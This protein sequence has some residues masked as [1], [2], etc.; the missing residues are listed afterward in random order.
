MKKHILVLLALVI[1][2][3]VHAGLEFHQAKT[4][5]TEGWV[6][7][8]LDDKPIWINPNIEMDSSQVESASLE[9]TKFYEQRKK[10][11]DERIAEFEKDHPGSTIKSSLNEYYISI[12]LTTNG[13]AIFQEITTKLC[14]DRLAIIN[15]GELLYA[16]NVNEPITGGIVWIASNNKSKS[17]LDTLVNEI[18]TDK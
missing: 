6:K 5:E 4:E 3:F 7:M 14:G 12:Q 17:D 8:Q 16:P 18:N 9:R 13:A 2:Q 15:N 11:E 10:A 1:P